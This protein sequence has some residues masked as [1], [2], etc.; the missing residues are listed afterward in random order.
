M[1]KYFEA[2]ENRASQFEK[3]ILEDN[4]DDGRNEDLWNVHR[5]QKYRKCMDHL[6]ISQ[7]SCW[8]HDA[9]LLLCICDSMSLYIVCFQILER[10]RCI[11]SFQVVL[12]T[13]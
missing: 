3:L 7:A 1:L 4:E 13:F 12:K 5:L 2:S 8:L 10:L 6:F 9:I 11:P